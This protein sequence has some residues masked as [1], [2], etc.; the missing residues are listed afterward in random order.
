MFTWDV[1]ARLRNLEYRGS[2]LGRRAKENDWKLGQMEQDIVM[3]LSSI[4]SSFG[5]DTETGPRVLLWTT[6]VTNPFDVD[7]TNVETA[8]T[9]AGIDYTLMGGGISQA[10]FNLYDVVFWSRALGD[11]SWIDFLDSWRGRL[12]IS[13]EAVFPINQPSNDYINAL[14]TSL[15]YSLQLVSDDVDDPFNNG[16]RPTDTHSLTDGITCLRGVYTSLVTGG[17]SLSRT[18][19]TNQTWLAV[20]RIG[21]V[22]VVLSGDADP[23][24]TGGTAAPCNNAGFIVNCS[25]ILV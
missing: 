20:E 14:L 6:N 23:F 15:G 21:D 2:E 17:T 18:F 8:L 25:Q 1:E 11:A 12:I 5:G 19:S 10:N 9:A 4:S 24:A 22:E 3:L 16:P 13:G 7:Y